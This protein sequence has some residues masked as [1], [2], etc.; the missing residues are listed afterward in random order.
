M[1]NN[2]ILFLIYNDNKL[3]TD[4]YTNY[5]KKKR[6]LFVLLQK[7]MAIDLIILIQIS[8]THKYTYI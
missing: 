2:Q 7:G 5:T 8:I 1:L 6:Q 3:E 4:Y